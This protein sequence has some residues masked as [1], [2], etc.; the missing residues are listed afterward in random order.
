MRRLR[1]HPAEGVNLVSC[2]YQADGSSSGRAR[3]D[4]KCD[5]VEYFFSAI[6]IYAWEGNP[7]ANVFFFC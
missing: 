6:F 5:G 1:H 4:K 3:R 2:A 7:Y